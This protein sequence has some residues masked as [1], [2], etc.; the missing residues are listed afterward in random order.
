[1]ARLTK[2]Q[3]NDLPDVEFAGPKR[4]F[5]IPDKSHAIA[6]ERLAPR[7]EKAGN[8][9]HATE[10]AIVAK[11]KKKLAGNHPSSRVDSGAAKRD[12]YSPRG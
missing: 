5:P 10:Q 9:S 6:A 11:A 3:R 4:S 12:H 7:S 8:I 1:M 2:K